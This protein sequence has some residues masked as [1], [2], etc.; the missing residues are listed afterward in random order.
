MA[1]CTVIDYT[2]KLVDQHLDAIT[3]ASFAFVNSKMPPGL[4]RAGRSRIAGEFGVF[5]SQLYCEPALRSK[6]FLHIPNRFLG[7]GTEAISEMLVILSDCMLQF[8]ALSPEDRAHAHPDMAKTR[9]LCHATKGVVFVFF[10]PHASQQCF[11]SVPNACTL[12]LLLLDVLQR[13]PPHFA[14]LCSSLKL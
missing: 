6:G 5:K 4:N 8:W 7:V 11:N 2:T 12:L 1:G 3:A 9:M 10:L 13:R 14:T